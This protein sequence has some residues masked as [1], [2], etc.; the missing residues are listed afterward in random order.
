MSKENVGHRR[1][2]NLKMLYIRQNM[3]LLNRTGNRWEAE[4]FDA[5]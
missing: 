2:L 5:D 1:Y 3:A 4:Y